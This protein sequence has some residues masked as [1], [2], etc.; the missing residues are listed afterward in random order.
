MDVPLSKFKA[1]AKQTEE[2][3]RKPFPP[4]YI[5]EMA[6]DGIKREKYAVFGGPPSWHQRQA[7]HTCAWIHVA[8]FSEQEILTFLDNNKKNGESCSARKIV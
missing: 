3:I 2:M 4:E 5:A 7:G 8:L 1:V 6:K